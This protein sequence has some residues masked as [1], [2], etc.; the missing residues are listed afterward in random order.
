MTPLHV[1]LIYFI[2]ALLWIVFSDNILHF[3]VSEPE[4][5]L[6]YQSLKGITFILLSSIL[7]YYLAV[8]L[9]RVLSREV[10]SRRAHLA[11]LRRKAY[12]DSLTG[13]A[14]RRMGL[15]TLRRM[16]RNHQHHTVPFALLFIDLDNF[17]HINDTLGHLVGDKVIQAVARKLG[18]CLQ[19][20]E[21]LVRQGGDEFIIIV[22]SGL[23][24]P[25]L[26]R[27]AERVLRAFEKPLDIE[28]LALRVSVSIGMTRFPEDGT[29]T[30]LLLRNADLALHYSKKSKAAYRFYDESMSASFRYQ[31]DLEQGLRQA[32]AEAALRVHYQPF[33]SPAT[34]ELAGAEA[35]VRWP[36]EKG[37]ISPA[38]FIPVAEASGQI[39]ALGAWVLKHACCDTRL[40]SDQCG[41]ALTVSVNVSP[42]QFF[43]RHILADLQQAL[44]ISGIDPAQVILEITEGVF[45]SQ[46]ADAAEVLDSLV[47]M[48]V[49]L[50]MDDFGQG[51][52]SLSYLRMH[53]FSFLKIDQ[54]FIQGMVHSRQDHALVQASVAMARALHLG[55]V[56]E[57]VETS[58]QWEELKKLAIDFAQGFYLAKPMALADYRKLVCPEYV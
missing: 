9:N 39:R 54:S 47:A 1:A 52:S 22:D 26:E 12:T 4:R 51:Y 25:S 10:R 21:M 15:R 43:N 55:I 31:F 45:I 34:G 38:D 33:F 58:E 23:D 11:Q 42:V 57:G 13:L 32:L 46:I 2:S 56:A 41:K 6:R 28:G 20:S 5:L 16:M 30:S 36:S 49:R 35:L 50:A 44:N 8:R 18:E 24:R 27:Y 53:P 29:S 14:N 48:G 19:Y 7:V 3:L 37:F 17:K 40:L